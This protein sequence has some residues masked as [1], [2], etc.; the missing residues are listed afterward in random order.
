MAL[1]EEQD[2]NNQ[3][4]DAFDIGSPFEP[5]PL[6]VQK[7]LSAN[8]FYDLQN[9]YDTKRAEEVKKITIQNAKDF[10]T[11]EP[12]WMRNEIYDAT[13]SKA[14]AEGLDADNSAVL[15][16]TTTLG[17]EIPNVSAVP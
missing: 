9:I 1:T 11:N 5:S 14:Q 6:D 10:R 7:G 15:A 12:N 13:F 3:T 8:Q 16:Y 2:V 17:A 4:E